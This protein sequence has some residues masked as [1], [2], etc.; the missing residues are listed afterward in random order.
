MNKIKMKK[1][2][3]G[4]SLAEAVVALAVV[5]IITVAALTMVTSSIV[6]TINA[7]NKA[8]AQIFA[9]NVWE[10]FKA[11]ENEDKFLENVEFAIDGTLMEQGINKYKYNA[12]GFNAKIEVNSSFTEL[13][14]TV[15]D[16]KGEQIVSLNYTKGGG[17]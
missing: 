2:R 6:A 1:A 4:F 15:N 14:V 17:A 7:T 13:T 10:C 12:D 16:N 3:R 5:V 9:Q 8:E 11:S